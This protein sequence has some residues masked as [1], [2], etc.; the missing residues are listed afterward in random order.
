MVELNLSCILNTSFNFSRETPEELTPR[1]SDSGKHSRQKEESA[2]SVKDKADG[3]NQESSEKETKTIKSEEQ[4]QEEGIQ[5]EEGTDSSV[6]ITEEEEEK[7][8]EE[9]KQEDEEE[10]QEKMEVDFCR[11]QISLL[12]L[13]AE[14]FIKVYGIIT[15]LT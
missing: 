1:K 14:A 2:S 6:V 12:Q 11:Y 9:E 5:L 7:G 10:E 4:N 15:V 8:E 3:S 13:I